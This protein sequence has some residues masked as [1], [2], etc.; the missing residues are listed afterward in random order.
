M[1]KEENGQVEMEEEDQIRIVEKGVSNYFLKKH[2]EDLRNTKCARLIYR[3][4]VGL[5]AFATIIF[6]L[7]RI[8]IRIQGVSYCLTEA[9]AYKASIENQL[10][11]WSISEAIWMAEFYSHC[12]GITALVIFWVLC[13]VYWIAE[14]KSLTKEGVYNRINII[15][16]IGSLLLALLK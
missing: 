14:A 10:V 16:A 5:L 8:P 11:E 2:E 7:T 13:A 15:I 4:I 12:A 9:L 6:C 1:R 3:L